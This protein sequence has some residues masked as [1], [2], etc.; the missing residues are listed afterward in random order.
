MSEERKNIAVNIQH[1]EEAFGMDL[2]EFQPRNIY[3]A[4]ML[5]NALGLLH[6]S[7]KRKLRGD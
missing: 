3:P 1:L 5:F 2:S 6:E 4:T 7:S